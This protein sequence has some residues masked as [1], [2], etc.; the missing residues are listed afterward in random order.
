M[1]TFIALLLIQNATTPGTVTTPYPT[2]ENLAVEWAIAGDADNDGVVSTK[3]RVQGTTPWKNGMPLKRVPAGSNAGFS[4]TNKHSGSILGL[5][6]GTTYEI[7]LTLTDPDGGSTVT[8]VTATTR[9]VP[10]APANATVIPVTPSNF[11]SAAAAANP[12]DVLLLEP[13]NYAGFTFTRSGTASQPIVIRGGTFN[14]NVR[15]DGLSYVFLED[16]TV[17]GMIKFNGATGIVV[18]RCTITAPSTGGVIAYSPNGSTAGATQCTI[19]DNVVLGPYPFED[20]YL[21]ANGATTAEGI[22]M[23]G[24][25]NVI[26]YN[27]VRGFRDC[28]SFLEGSG[29]AIN[30]I[31][32]DVYGNDLEVGCDDGIEAD[33]AMGNCRIYRNRLTNCFV[34]L[35]SQPSIGGP[36][37]F[38]RNELYNCIYSPFK[39]HNGSVGDIA[40]HNTVVKCGDA[41]AVYS[42]AT[43]SR[44]VFRNNLFL[45]GSGG[46]TYGGY[47]N[48]NGDVADLGAADATCS[49]NYDGYGS[50]GTGT[51]DGNIG[52]TSFTSLAQ[53]KSSTTET[54]AVQVTMSVFAA[55]VAFPDPPLPERPKADLRL[56]SG[57]AAADA[58]VAIANVND[59]YSGSAPDLGA[60]ELGS[61]LP[62]YGPRTGS[63][64]GGGGGSGGGDSGG[65]GEG[66][67]GCGLLGIEALLILLALRHG[68]GRCGHRPS[69]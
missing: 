64:G 63:S 38:L 17:N 69:P 5:S 8:V 55:S 33:Y 19:E 48:G 46:G 45:G 23:T 52:G 24:P 39:L 31:C 32:N 44:A 51:F 67:E 40:Y 28:I 60:H 37:Y 9:V 53:M 61:P 4:W 10:E 14:G 1:N 62:T 29:S 54:N 49:F 18:R 2:F 11:A 27:R 59:G 21:G 57:S 47:D 16:A 42:G 3:Y 25:G 58:G 66:S 20:A 6:P 13:G 15:F 12:G 41:F 35:S 43:W 22:Q 50:V 65:G 34:G 7:E 30:Q 56:A 36:T 68:E 26:R